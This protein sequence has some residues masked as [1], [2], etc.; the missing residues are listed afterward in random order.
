MVV[1]VAFLG[2]FSYAFAL[3]TVSA[4]REIFVMPVQTALA[5]NDDPLWNDANA[6]GW[7]AVV[8]RVI[9]MFIHAVFY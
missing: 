6:P 9:S 4:L 5:R 8:V 1:V 7:S 3:M 2:L